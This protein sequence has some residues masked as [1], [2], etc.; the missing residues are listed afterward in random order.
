VDLDLH[1]AI[2]D[3]EVARDRPNELGEIDVDRFGRSRAL[4]EPR[5]DQQFLDERCEVLRVGFDDSFRV[6][7]PRVGGAGTVRGAVRRAGRS[8]SVPRQRPRMP[9]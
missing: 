2:R 5:G 3:A 7:E 1:R 9:R 4:H 6:E 8:T